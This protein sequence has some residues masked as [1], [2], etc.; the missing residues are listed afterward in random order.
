[1]AYSN[2]MRSNQGLVTVAAVFSMLFG[3]VPAVA[4]ILVLAGSPA[5][6]EARY[7]PGALIDDGRVNLA[8]GEWIQILADG[9]VRRF[10]GPGA[11]NA[12]PAKPAERT[13][14]ERVAAALREVAMRRASLGAVRGGIG[15]PTPADVWAVDTSSADTICVRGGSDVL[16]WRPQSKSAVRASIEEVSNSGRYVFTW[17]AGKET[18]PWPSAQVRPATG[19]YRI[20]SGASPRQIRLVVLSSASDDLAL[21]DALAQAQCYTQLE[22][23]SE[24]K[25]P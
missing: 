24:R 1:M 18:A 25:S 11:L 19:D 13:A 14:L 4:A 12:R 5:S 15:P 8:A 6:V 23:L 16:L 21:W 9:T 17:P 3:A 10:T 2:W 7:P 20:A 22:R